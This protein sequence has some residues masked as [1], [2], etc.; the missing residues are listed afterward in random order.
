MAELSS[1]IHDARAPLGVL[2]YLIRAESKELALSAVEREL[3]Y[4]DRLLSQGAPRKMMQDNLR[5]DVGEVVARVYRRYAQ[6][7]G[8]E[9][10]QFERGYIASYARASDLDVERI[11]T[12]VVGNAKRHAPDARTVLSV[13]SHG[14]T[15]CIAVLD[16]GPGISR[17]VLDALESERPLSPQA[18]SGWGIGLRSCRAKV[19]ELGG[20]LTI[21]SREGVGTEV[22]VI[23]PSTTPPPSREGLHVADGGVAGPAS[24]GEIR[25]YVV[26]DD[27]EHASSFSRLLRRYG[28][29]VE[30]F[31]SIHEVVSALPHRGEGI[32]LCDAHMPDGGAERLLSI[33]STSARVPCFAVVSGD[34]TDEYLY[35]LAGLGA[36]AFFAKPVEVSDVVQWLR[37]FRG[38]S[39]F[40]NEPPCSEVLP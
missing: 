17:D 36:Q 30:E 26:D 16:N 20:D 27:V 35:K 5:C 29:S 12:N 6:E 37:T 3:E 9:S 19:K 10:V 24:S 8:S 22:A 34:A 38:R 21:A 1:L 23:L 2:K 31:H 7:E 18:T 32:I 25:V 33:L 4:L 11:V 13:E 14:D 40:L 39:A 15:V 28:F